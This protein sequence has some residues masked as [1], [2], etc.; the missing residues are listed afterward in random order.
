MESFPVRDLTITRNAAT[1]D[2]KAG[3]ITLIEP[4]GDRYHA[5]LFR[6]QGT[7]HFRPADAIERD[8]LH[9]FTGTRILEE[10]FQ[11][12]LIRFSDST[13]EE[14]MAQKGVMS[15]ASAMKQPCD[16]CMEVR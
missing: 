2:L 3:E 9:K 4:L 8:Q 1:I 11:S 7:F 16:P 5:A 10:P 12:I 14:L 15:R 6:G 13:A